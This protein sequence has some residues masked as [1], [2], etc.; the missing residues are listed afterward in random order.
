VDFHVV[1]SAKEALPHDGRRSPILAGVS[2]I[3]T[4]H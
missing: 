1:D 4:F 3:G 2:A